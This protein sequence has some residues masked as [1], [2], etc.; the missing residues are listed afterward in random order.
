MSG[1]GGLRFQGKLT[2]VHLKP[3]LLVQ[4]PAPMKQ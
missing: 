1:R 4:A 2:S 3:H